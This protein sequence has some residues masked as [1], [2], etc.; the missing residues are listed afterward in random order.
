MEANSLSRVGR[1]RSVLFRV[2]TVGL[3]L[4]R[5]QESSYAY[6]KYPG[7]S[8]GGSNG[9]GANAIIEMNPL[10]K[11]RDGNYVTLGDL[12]GQY[13]DQYN[14]VAGED[15]PWPNSY[16]NDQAIPPPPI[17][18]MLY[19]FV[20]NLHRS[21]PTLSYGTVSSLIIFVF[22]QF[23]VLARGLLQNHFVCSS[24]NVIR[25]KRIHT[26]FLSAISHSSFRHLFVNLYAFVTFGS[27]VQKVIPRK[28]K[29]NSSLY[30]M[31]VD[32]LLPFV[33]GSAITG[34]L[35]HLLLT[36][37]SG[38]GSLGLSGVT[39]A[40]FAFIARVYPSRQL[41]II[42]LPKLRIY[43]YHALLF[44]IAAS[45]LGVLS[46]K[47]DGVAHA[48]HLGGLAFGLGYHEAFSRGWLQR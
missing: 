37:S 45:V 48:T 20:M 29:R 16:G 18:E 22:W 24:Y 15:V 21:S 2:W 39:F 8:G 5:K 41:R 6:E 14:T 7:S 23:P 32:S 30:K 19:T 43:F 33:L 9:I 38:A 10:Y 40:L 25:K 12:D 11:S 42:F 1:K 34:S 27:D 17:K 46:G 44:S 31:S 47:H 13:K 3:L 4:L 36:H 35:C 28:V 26:M